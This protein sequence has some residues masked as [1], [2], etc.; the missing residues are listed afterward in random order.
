[1]D[2]ASKCALEEDAD[3]GWVGE[4]LVEL[5]RPTKEEEEALKAFVGGEADGA[6][7]EADASSG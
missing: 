4:L 3:E 2:A 5:L 7:P 1:M 6:I